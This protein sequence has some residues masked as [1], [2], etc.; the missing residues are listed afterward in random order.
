MLGNRDQL[1]RQT[2]RILEREKL[3]TVSFPNQREST[4]GWQSLECGKL[5]KDP[6][7]TSHGLQNQREVL[8]T[9]KGESCGTALVTQW[10]R[11][12]LPMQGTQ[13]RALVWEDATEQQS[14]CA[15]T[16]EPVSHNY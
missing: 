9:L 11:S 4:D 7:K 13:V 10:L 14:P 1:F 16:T 8:Q 6:R 5:N 12:C 3:R 15:T 2:Y